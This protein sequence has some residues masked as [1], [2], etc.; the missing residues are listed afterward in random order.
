[1]RPWMTMVC[2]AVTA[3][4]VCAQTFS[5]VIELSNGDKIN[6]EVIE[7]TDDHLLV[8]H[9]VLGRLT[10]PVAAAK[11]VEVA[12]EPEPEPEPEKL[13]DPRLMGVAFL[14]GWTRH[15][16][17]GL[18]GTSGNSDSFNLRAG[19]AARRE[20]ETDRWQI[21][22]AFTRSTSEGTTTRNDFYSELIKDWLLP[23]QKH[24]Y[25]AQG[26]YDY[27]DF[28]SWRHRAAAAGG[29]GYQFYDTPKFN[30]LGRVG[31]GVNESWGGDADDMLT[32]EALFG[33]E[34]WW[35]WC[36]TQ[37]LEFKSTF[38]PAL[39]DLGEFR[40]L[41]SLAYVLKLDNAHNLSLKLG[42]ENEYESQV[43]DGIKHNDFKYF[44]ALVFDF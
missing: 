33:L 18:D 42:L 1:M 7:R 23:G 22:S 21:N 29:V 2:A 19:F 4:A 32:P 28:Q 16:E 31:G 40:N 20:D 43:E 37:R 44:A 3:V 24:F 36:D 5:E 39:D 11:T 8:E 41:S 6:V 14:P 27:D 25:F 9:P 13:A 10:I 15:I 35:Q 12:A 17:L 34:G 30:L 38:Y 26:R